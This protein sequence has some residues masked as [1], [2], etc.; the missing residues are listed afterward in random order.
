M[1]LSDEM[2]VMP[3]SDAA[4]QVV[5]DIYFVAEL[6]KAHELPIP[7][8]FAN[9]LTVAYSIETLMDLMP[10]RAPLLETDLVTLEQ[11]VL[12]CV[13]HA[14]QELSD[15]I[16]EQV[17]S[18]TPQQAYR[19]MQLAARRALGENHNSLMDE[20]E[21]IV[22]EARKVCSLELYEYLAV[23]L[24]LDEDDYFDMLHMIG[25]DRADAATVPNPPARVK[26]ALSRIRKRRE[27]LDRE[28][29][30]PPTEEQKAS[31]ISHVHGLAD[32]KQL[33]SSAI[34]RVDWEHGRTE[35]R[36]PPDQ[37]RAVEA[38]IDGL[39]LR[40]AESPEFLGWT[41]KRLEAVRRSLEPDRKWGRALQQRFTDYN[42]RRD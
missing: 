29:W 34:S 42:P 28:R 31:A 41:A 30:F 39:N 27:E 36:L 40:G 2:T 26:T 15:T 7:E 9:V 33:V 12:V 20:F 32:H 38:K 23:D 16:S 10:A 19:E 18:E 37:T 4:E 13:F 17:H 24:Q 21:W 1:S 22:P 11:I 25:H 5:N 8:E 35:I 6:V 14:A 3:W